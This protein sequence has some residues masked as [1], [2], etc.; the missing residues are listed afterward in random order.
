MDFKTPKLSKDRPGV[1][2]SVLKPVSSW[3]FIA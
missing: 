2:L 1:A 3:R